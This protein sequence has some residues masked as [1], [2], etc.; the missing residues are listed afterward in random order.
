MQEWLSMKV[1]LHCVV[2]LCLPRPRYSSSEGTSK[3]TI[4]IQTTCYTVF[5]LLVVYCVS[6]GQ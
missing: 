1:H 4:G 2:A 5:Y 3:E 6:Q